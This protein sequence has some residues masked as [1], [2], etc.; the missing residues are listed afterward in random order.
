MAKV[1]FKG[2]FEILKE[3]GKKFSEDKIPKL[4]G[5]LAYTIVFSLAPLLIVIISLCGI[6]LG[7]EA[8]QG[9]VNAQLSGFLGEKSAADLQEIIK[10]A[11]LSGK[12]TGAAIIG[13]FFLLI[14]AT[15][16]FAEI[17]DSINTIWQIKPKPKK[18]WLAYLRNRFLSFSVI[19]SLGFL[20][21]I[22]LGLSALI[23]A[24]SQQ[25]ENVF[26]DVTV[27][28]F[29]II[30]L[31]LSF[32]IAV[33]IFAVIFK[34]LPDAQIRWRDVWAGA[35]AT[36]ILFL[37]GKFAIS[38]YISKAGIGE[39]YGA[40]GSIVI[41]LVWI[42]YSAFI[43]YFGAEFTRAYAVKYGAG[44]TPGK[45]AVS[46]KVVEVEKNEANPQ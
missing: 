21:L 45:Y 26:P 18:G 30:N 8:I 9:S 2:L 14:G 42:Y 12:S 37:L 34:V 13:G 24:F 31:V 46:T 32:I 3:A 44:I 36:G 43:L 17:Q 15:A 39:T 38:L 22:S 19:I 4:S 28:I 25:L 29:K 16:V 5:S 11:S 1:T 6:F 33:I 10:N 41:L 35:I 23:D 40:A 27:T 20:L 7:D